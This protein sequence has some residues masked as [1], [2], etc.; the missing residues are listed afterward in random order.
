MSVRPLTVSPEPHMLLDQNSN[1][2]MRCT[3]PGSSLRPEDVQATSGMIWVRP[4]P[5]TAT[6]GKQD[7]I[8]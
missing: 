8:A 6:K 1:Q 5:L 4:G 2:W 7:G 3:T